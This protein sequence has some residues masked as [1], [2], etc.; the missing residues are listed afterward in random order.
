MTAVAGPSWIPG[1]T[2]LCPAGWQPLHSS[3]AW[4]MVEQMPVS[5]TFLRLTLAAIGAGCAFMLGRSAVGFRRRSVRKSTLYAWAIRTVAC[6]LAVAF[7]FALD[8]VD[9]AVWCISAAAFVSGWWNGSRPRKEE[10]L[11]HVMFPDGK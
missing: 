8:A 7:R 6:L 2:G 1:K 5:F 4:S 3:S 10:D 9:I 11:T